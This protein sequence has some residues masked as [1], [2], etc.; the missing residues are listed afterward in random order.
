MRIGIPACHIYA[1]IGCSYPA[2]LNEPIRGRVLVLAPHPDDETL[3]CGGTIALH[4]KQ[5]DEVHL[6]VATDGAEGDPDGVYQGIDYVRLR[7]KET[8]EAAVFLGIGSM[9]FWD[10]PD[11]RLAEVQGL[12]ERLERTISGFRP[13]ILYYPSSMEAH[14]DHQA[15]GR[16][17]ERML[18]KGMTELEALVYEIWA[19]IQPTHIV[20]ITTVWDL[21]LQAMQA[22]QSQTRYNDYIHKIG[23]LNAYR[24]IYMPSAGYAE[25]FLRWQPS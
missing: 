25:A 3:G 23:G 20:N 5:G 4:T 16:A 14:P 7:R 6:V 19:P 21:K 24:S 18:E 1:M 2:I 11:G 15:L 12:S 17:V 10:Y 13:S 9:E 22:Y 8:H